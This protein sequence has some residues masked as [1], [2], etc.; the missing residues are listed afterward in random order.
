[1]EIFRS[2]CSQRSNA[3]LRDLEKFAAVPTTPVSEYEISWLITAL[4]YR[5][6]SVTEAHALGESVSLP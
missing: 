6:L 1:M 3:L 2:V 5:G 4:V